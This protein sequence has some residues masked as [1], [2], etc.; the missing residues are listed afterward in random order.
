M[1]TGTLRS[2]STAVLGG[3]CLCQLAVSAVPQPVT[4]DTGFEDASLGRIEVMG[5]NEFRLHVEGQNDERGHNRQANWFYFRMDHV[6]GREL[7]LTLTD[8]VGEYDD[9]PGTVALGPATHPVF[10][11]DNE[12]WDYFSTVG[13]DNGRKE[14]ILKC[15]P[16]A[17]TLWIAYVPPYPYS[18]MVRLLEEIGRAACA[19]VE[20]VGRTA[21]GRELPIVTVTN[22]ARPDE[23]KKL[24]WLITRQHAWEAG[25]SFAAEGALRFITSDDPRAK[26]L[27]DRTIFVFAPMADPDGC[28]TGKVR[29]N[30]HGYDFNRYWER[31]DLR[32]KQWLERMPEVWYLKKAILAQQ[33]RHPIDLVVNFH[34]NET[35]EYMETMV[36]GGP[37]LAMLQHFFQTLKAESSFDP[38]RAEASVVPAPARPATNVLWPEDRVPVILLEQ[39]IV[40]SPK[41]GRI[42]TPEDR[43]ALGRDLIKVMAEVVR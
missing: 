25:T 40:K 3:L 32:D 26:E 37:T 2:L 17:D 29:Y 9:H 38:S 1:T 13:W 41:L 11:S 22:S 14:M 35:N 24:V 27:R 4:F 43:M 7:T 33:A 34:N 18:R 30:A 28:A 31:V 6:A 23:A 20:I 21:R 42:A 10:S 8:L 15:R 12:H 16:T 39:R 5:A 36:D 19:R